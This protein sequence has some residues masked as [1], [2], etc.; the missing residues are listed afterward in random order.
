VAKVVLVLWLSYS[1]SKKGARVREFW[2][3]VVP[4]LL[5]VALLMALCLKQ[6]DFGSA[7][8]L[9]LLA[10]TMMFA[11]GVR[12]PYLASL[13]A[14]FGLAAAALVRFSGYRYARF[15]SWLDLEQHK[16][17]LAYQPFQSVMSFGSGGLFGLGLGRGLQVLYLPEAHTDFV[18]AIVGEELGFVGVCLMCSVYALVVARGVKIAFEAADDYGSFIAFGLS[19]MVGIQVLTNLAVA[20]AI[21]PTKGLTLP[22]VSYGGSSLL[23]SAAAVG[24]LLNISRPRA[25]TEPATRAEAATEGPAP[26]ASAVV[27]TS[28]EEGAAGW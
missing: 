22:F 10:F 2:V 7:V 27:A 16:E 14:T 19:A 9:L 28:A 11:A 1:L 8:V 25:A 21:L 17:G 6:P 20:M 18:A 5:V 15:M 4:H 13:L 26:S 24:V 23:V 3:G 12:L